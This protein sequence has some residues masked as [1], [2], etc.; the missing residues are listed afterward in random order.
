MKKKLIA[1]A[2]SLAMALVMI[3]SA[4]FAWF[5]VSTAPEVTFID[6][7]MAAYKNLEIGVGSSAPAEVKTTDTGKLNHWGAS[8]NYSTT[9]VKLTQMATLDGGTVKTATIDETGRVGALAAASVATTGTDA[10]TGDVA[11]TDGATPTTYKDNKNNLCA[12]KYNLW[13]RSNADQTVTATATG[14]F[15]NG[16]VLVLWDGATATTLDAT[17]D[18]ATFSLTENIAK[19]ITVYAFVDGETHY[20]KDIAAGA[21]FEG[22][23]TFTGSDTGAGT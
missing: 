15:T 19:N 2:V 3:T 6:V 16:M 13:L 14:T 5:T 23:I 10:G 21:G 22:K 1:S 8:V 20:A 12:A 11:V 4:S 18:T 17:G 7:E 9:A